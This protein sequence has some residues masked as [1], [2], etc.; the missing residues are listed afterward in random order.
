MNISLTDLF[1]SLIKL[2]VRVDLVVMA[3]KRYSSLFRCP[4][5]EP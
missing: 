4:E 5:V 3:I 1:D 2:W